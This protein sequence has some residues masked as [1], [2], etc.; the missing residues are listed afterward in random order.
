MRKGRIKI[1][2][3]DNQEQREK[4]LVVMRKYHPKGKEDKQREFAF[5]LSEDR[6]EHYLIIMDPTRT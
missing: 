5:S 3:T 4:L 6:L 1:I 2:R